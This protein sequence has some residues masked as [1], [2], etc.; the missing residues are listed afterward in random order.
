MSRLLCACLALGMSACGGTAITQV[1][2]STPLGTLSGVVQNTRFEP[3]EGATVTLVL[4]K[5]ADGS[6]TFKTSTNSQGAF[7]FQGLPAGST[8][9]V[10]V[11]KAGFGSG[12]QS[13]SV[14]ATA[15]NFPLNDGNGNMGILILTELNTTVRFTVYSASGKPAK[16]ARGLLEVTPA[17][18]FTVSSGT[19]GSS[20]G[21]TN[22]EAVADDNGALI[23]AGVPSPAEMTRVGGTY[24]LTIGALDEDN[25]GQIDSLGT[26][27]AYSGV[28]L[29]TNPSQTI[30]LGAAGT[31]APL[32]ITAAS[33]ESLT[34]LAGTPPPYLNAV[35]PSEAI[36]VV[37]NQPIAEATRTVKVVEEDCSRNVA[38][39]VTQRAPNVLSITPT[40]AWTTGAEYHLVIRA[41]GLDSGTTRDFRGYFFAIDPGAPRPLGTSAT[42]YAKKAPGAMNAGALENGDELYVV[43]DTP[44][45]LLGGPQGRAF[46][47]FDLNNNG[48]VGGT[49][50][51]EI[52]AMPTTLGF[53]IDLAEETFDPMA[54]TFTCRTNSYGSR[55]RISYGALPAG[56][57]PNNTT[58]RVILPSEQSSA[59]GYQTAWGQ[60]ATGSVN[61]NLTIRQ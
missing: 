22:V 41:T 17:A 55:Y 44:L 43:F 10:A 2:P 53:P 49:D 58:M 57:V 29:F 5:G 23:F 9:Q 11:S 35:K 24:Q 34:N 7:F 1:A 19:Y 3:I 15:G 4:G 36:T 12:R 33:L 30:V 31:T 39:T 6:A 13:V 45:A 27:R 50:P 56:G 38:V 16:G 59:T 54:S 32:A 52:G 51:G 37:F 8:G 18:L 20:Q 26:S 46:I 14:P 28:T 60:S 21:V 48:S 25:D 47:G 40:T 42:F 61:G